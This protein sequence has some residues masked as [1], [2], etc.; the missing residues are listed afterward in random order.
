MKF[1][2]ESADAGWD[3]GHCDFS[4]CRGGSEGWVR[5]VGR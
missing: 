3:E 4:T 2:D 5:R 1:G